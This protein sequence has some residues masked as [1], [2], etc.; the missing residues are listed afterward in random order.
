MSE[1][2]NI[3]LSEQ[4]VYDVLKFAENLRPLLG[5]GVYTPDMINQNLQRVNMNPR[6]AD[7]DKVEKALADLSEDDLIGFS[8]YYELTD[9]LYKRMLGYSGN[10]L[11]FDL[12]FYPTNAEPKDL[13]SKKYKKDEKRIK[14]FLESFDYKK[15]FKKATRLMASR[16]VYFTQFRRDGVKPFLQQMPENYAKITGRFEYGLLYDMNMYWF[17]QP[18]VDINMYSDEVKQMYYDWY[19]YSKSQ[20]YRPSSSLDNRKG[21]YSYWKQTSPEQGFFCWKFNPDVVSKVPYF[22]PLLADIALKPLIRNLQTNIYFLQAQKLLV[23]TIPLLNDRSGGKVTDALAIQPETMGKFLSL[24]RQGLHDSIKIGAAPFDE[25]EEIDFSTANNNIL[26][27]YTQTTSAM[28]GTNSRL[29]FGVD[30]PNALETKLSSEIDEFLVTHLYP[31]FEDFLNYYANMET[32]DFKFRFKFEGTEFSANR[33]ERQELQFKLMDKGIVMKQKIAAS[34]GMSI[35]EME[36][37]MAMTD[38]DDFRDA[39]MPLLSAYNMPQNQGESKV[40]NR[41]KKAVEDMTDSGMATEESGANEGRG[42]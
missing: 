18:S 11:S 15:E 27:Q 38:A 8:E 16:E 35:K 22:A 12:T 26:Q 30:K 39:I 41:P 37:Y 21:T 25:I 28:S 33:K 3:Q 31:Y 29:L 10:M 19:E 4:E 5:N 13:K 2:Q 36:M 6:I 7:K 14:D 34:L 20:S 9:M 24:L 17:M 1:E 42:E 40:A 32:T 23:G